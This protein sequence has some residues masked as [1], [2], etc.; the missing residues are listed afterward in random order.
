VG[1]TMFFVFGVL[2]GFLG[3][4]AAAPLTAV[5]LMLVKLLYVEDVLEASA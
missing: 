4:I 2:F 1:I 3:L 5:M